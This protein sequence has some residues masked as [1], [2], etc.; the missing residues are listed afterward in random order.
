MSYEYE[1]VRPILGH[2]IGTQIG[3]VSTMDRAIETGADIYQFF[4]R[5]SRSY[6]DFSRPKEQT[7]E[8]ANKLD[9]HDKRVV[10]HASYI[11]N[12]CQ[13]QTDYRHFKG[14]KI[15]I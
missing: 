5:P 11:I 10:I 9:E 6:R 8:L 1:Y 14:V 12:M 2:N 7:Q 4:Y 3:Y 15:K 13:P